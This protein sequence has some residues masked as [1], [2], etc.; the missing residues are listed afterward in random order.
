MAKYA[1][2]ILAVYDNPDDQ[3]KT[4]EKLEYLLRKYM[5]G[6]LSF[7]DNYG[8]INKPYANVVDTMVAELPS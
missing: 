1:I 2:V 6:S 7:D 3:V 8:F 5:A 4:A